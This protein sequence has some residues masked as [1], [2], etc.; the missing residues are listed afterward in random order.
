MSRF[1]ENFVQNL[2]G[3]LQS[4]S[5]RRTIKN[6]S[7]LD[8]CLREKVRRYTR[9]S[10]D[11]KDENLRKTVFTHG[12]KH[13][14]KSKPLQNVVVYGCSNTSDIFITEPR[15]G[16]I[17]IELK[18]AKRHTLPGELQRGIGQSL[19]ASLRHPYVICLVV[20]ESDQREKTPDELGEKLRALLWARHQ[21]ALVVRSLSY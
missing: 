16:S 7:D 17:Y 20:C 14:A 4:V 3:F 6:E 9:E 13:W 18:W 5:F 1:A 19:I 2:I 11:I 10:L 8:N 12:N 21:I 15:V